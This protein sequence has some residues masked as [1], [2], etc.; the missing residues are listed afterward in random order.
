MS[1][2][3]GQAK[4]FGSDNECPG[5]PATTLYNTI[6]HLVAYVKLYVW[7]CFLYYNYYFINLFYEHK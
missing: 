2:V 7:V 6:L 1:G 4:Q 5:R 3:E